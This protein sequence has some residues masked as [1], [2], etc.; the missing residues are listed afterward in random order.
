MLVHKLTASECREV[1][2]RTRHGR[3]ACARSDQP[4]VV[5]VSLYFDADEDALYSFS[6]I[7]QKIRWMRENPL[8]CVEVDEIQ[9]RHEWTTVVVFGR[10][11]EIPRTR[12]GAE[13]RRRAT[14]LFASQSQWWLPGAA[15]VASGDPHPLPVVYRI[16]VTK[17]TGRR[18]VPVS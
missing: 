15:T 9:S 18:A 11:D 1:L 5:P 17:V 4:Y 7:G 13:L 8:V 10:Y 3:L 6:T 14:E 16:R 12:E 2:A